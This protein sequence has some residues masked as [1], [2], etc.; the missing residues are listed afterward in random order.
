LVTFPGILYTLLELFIFHGTTAVEGASALVFTFLAMEAVKTYAF[1]P[2]YTIAGNEIPSWTTPGIWMVVATLLVPGSSFVG[3]LCG[4]VVG[5]A[6]AWRYM[7]ILEPSEWI[8]KKVEEKLGF[9]LLRLPWYVC[10]EK[11]TEMNYF[12]MLPMAAAPPAAAHLGGPG[13]TLG[14]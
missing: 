6:Y 10:L 13:R 1:Q 7:R 3:H 9:V 14:V 12:E 2:Y 8:L 5:Y 11:R 4:L